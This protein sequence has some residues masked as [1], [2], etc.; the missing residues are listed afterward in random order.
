MP[1]S[2]RKPDPLS[3]AELFEA[4]TFE[5]LAARMRPATLD[6]FMG[7]QQILAPGKPLR[8]AIEGG[9]IS[10]MIFWGPPGSGKTTLARLVAR[11]TDREFVSFSAV[12]EG[13][14]RVRELVADAE[15]R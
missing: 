2:R 4:R 12:T 1:H 5:P 7:Q 15:Q 6:E 10:S 3:N 14:Q 8:A 11:Y 13:V 9:T